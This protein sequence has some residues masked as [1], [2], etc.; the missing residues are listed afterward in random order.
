MNQDRSDPLT[1]GRMLAIVDELL[2]SNPYGFL[3]SHGSGG[4]T[5]LVHHLGESGGSEVWIGTSPRS[6]KAADVRAV[7]GVTYA[8]EDRNRFAYVALYADAE[9]VED[10]ATL[11]ARW[12]PD[13]EAFF[14]EGPLGGDFVLLRLAP[15]RIELMSFADAVHPEPYG[16]L[17]AALTRA[18]GSRPWQAVQADRVDSPP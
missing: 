2:A 4:H 17:P 13:L 9:V 5:R 1:A 6:R 18:D 8:V 3:V 14:P 16:L 12:V 15:W 10:A 7:P 11:E